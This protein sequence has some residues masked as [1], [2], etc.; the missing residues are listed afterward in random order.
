MHSPITA[1]A[2]SSPY[3]PPPSFYPPPPHSVY[4]LPPHSSPPPPSSS[5]LR[6]LES[7]REKRS[8][9]N[10]KGF[11]S[12]VINDSYTFTR[13]SRNPL[14]TY[15]VLECFLLILQNTGFVLLML[16]RSLLYILFS[17]LRPFCSIFS[18]LQEE[19]SQC[20][21]EAAHMICNSKCCDNNL[22]S[23]HCNI[24][25]CTSIPKHLLVCTGGFLNFIASAFF[26]ILTCC[27]ET[28]GKVFIE[29]I[30][31]V[32]EGGNLACEYIFG[33]IASGVG[34]ICE[35]LGH[36]CVLIVQCLAGTIF[37]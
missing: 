31:K 21:S 18:S 13:I 26:Q 35:G 28:V 19:L 8:T 29:G 36:S 5:Y 23:C 27:E 22:L 17:L 37:G 20:C 11:R 7:Q 12:Y 15:L 1:L 30:K 24:S 32:L 10:K 2:N 14:E 6:D 4:P 25:V 33:G 34:P 9:H 3:P 16:I